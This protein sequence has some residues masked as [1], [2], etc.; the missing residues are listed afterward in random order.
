VFTPFY[1]EKKPHVYFQFKSGESLFGIP[2][3]SALVE[4]FFSKT[5]FILRPHC[6]CMQDDLTENLFMSKKISIF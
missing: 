2:V 1:F 3:T 5:S 4:R 6:R